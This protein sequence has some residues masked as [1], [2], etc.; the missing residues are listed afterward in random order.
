[1]YAQEGGLSR[2][3]R[4][5]RAREMITLVGLAGAEEKLPRELSGGMARR[6]GLARALL[7]D[8]DLFLMD[9]PL[10]S[11]DQELKEKLILLLKER[12]QG[13]TAVLVTHDYNTAHQLSDHIFVMTA[14]PVKARE[15]NISELKVILDEINRD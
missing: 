12:L 5:E 10:A 3:E 11:L 6:V 9:E 15:I 13:K 2:H 4:K 1:M 7:T 8:F 14:P